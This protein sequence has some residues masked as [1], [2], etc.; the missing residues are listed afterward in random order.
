ML[1]WCQMCSS[2]PRVVT[3]SD[4][5][6]SASIALSSGVMARHTVRHVVPSWRP[7]LAIEACSRRSC[8]IVHQHARTVNN[9]R[10]ATTCRCSVKADRTRRLGADT[11]SACAT[12]PAPAARRTGASISSTVRRPWLIATTP[13]AGQPSGAGA[14]STVTVSRSGPARP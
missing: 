2:T 5:L 7:R 9:A 11:R 1:T 3:A 14:D 4:R 6:V 10:G 13:H 12:G 8:P